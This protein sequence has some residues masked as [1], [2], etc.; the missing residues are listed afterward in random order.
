MALWLN[1]RM[2]FV[3]G[4]K[5]HDDLFPDDLAETIWNKYIHR[6]M[7]SYLYLQ[8]AGRKNKYGKIGEC[9][10]KLCVLYYFL[11]ENTSKF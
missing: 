7:D 4:L 9:S 5:D 3:L 10:W 8:G 11:K 6:H 2:F 1:E